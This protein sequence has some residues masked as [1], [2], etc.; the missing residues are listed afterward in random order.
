[1]ANN[2]NISNLTLNDIILYNSDAFSSEELEDLSSTLNSRLTPEEIEILEAQS[3]KIQEDLD[4]YLLDMKIK[5][6]RTYDGDYDYPGDSDD[7]R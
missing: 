6:N 1:M 7:Y 2:K 4:E 5:D 3:S